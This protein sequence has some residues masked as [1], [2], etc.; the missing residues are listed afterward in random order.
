MIAATVQWSADE[1]RDSGISMGQGE[2]YTLHPGPMIFEDRSGGDFG[3]L[4]PEGHRLVA[5]ATAQAVIDR[6]FP[7][8]R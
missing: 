2:G 7:T 8:D 6:W 4:T 3:H 5:E 1:I